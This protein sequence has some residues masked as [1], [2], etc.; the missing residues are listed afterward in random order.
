VQTYIRVIAGE[1]I[2]NE[3]AELQRDIKEITEYLSRMS[4]RFSS[5]K[6]MLSQPPPHPKGGFSIFFNILEE[7]YSVIISLLISKGWIPCL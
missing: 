5:G 3:A 4:E 2:E 1:P 6:A 7:D